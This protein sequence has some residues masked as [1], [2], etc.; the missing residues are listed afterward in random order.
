MTLHGV[1]TWSFRGTVSTI[2]VCQC[3][4]L[5][6]ASLY[7]SRPFDP[8][9]E[10]PE[11]ARYWSDNG[12]EWFSWLLLL[13]SLLAPKTRPEEMS[14]FASVSISASVFGFVLFV[15]DKNGCLSSFYS[16][17]K[18]TVSPSSLCCYAI[19]DL[20]ENRSCMFYL[21]WTPCIKQCSQAK[22]YPISPTHFLCNYSLPTHPE[23]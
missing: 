10:P 13:G 23:M 15:S 4:C 16:L 1:L 21:P 19:G 6:S 22:K 2:S 12:P 3:I 9:P 7:A 8:L 20:A 11:A 17:S 5:Y 18:R 14:Q